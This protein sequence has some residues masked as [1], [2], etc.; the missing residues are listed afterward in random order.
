MQSRMD[1]YKGSNGTV[2]NNNEV[3]GTSR[4]SRNQELYKEVSYAELDNFDLNSNVSILGDNTANIDIGKI[5]DI[6]DEKYNEGTKRKSL[7]DTDEIELPKINLDETREYDIN[8]ILAKAKEEKEFDYEEDRLKK[9]NEDAESILKDIDADE[10]EFDRAESKVINKAKTDEAELLDLINT[11]TAKELIKEEANM[12]TLVGEMDPLDLLTDLRGDDDT[13]VMGAIDAVREIEEMHEE[14]LRMDK[15]D[16]ITIEEAEERE[17]E[18]ERTQGIEEITEEQMIAYD[19]ES[20]DDEDSE[21]DE[22]DD[23][24]EFAELKEDEET[25]EVKVVKG[26]EEFDETFIAGTAEF[27]KQDFDDFD[28]LKESGVTSVMVKILVFLIIIILILGGIVFGD[29]AVSPPQNI[30]QSFVNSGLLHI[31]LIL[32]LLF[33][34]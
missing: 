16:N 11:I 8:S 18:R 6:L 9:L 30:K 13:R 32:L 23:T 25:V 20:E 10:E 14:A 4:V 21:D 3:Q 27:S 2:D 22:E 19:E 26:I 28:D 5:R 24:T 15:E 17:D 7:G 29:D 1:R 33:S 31:F 12:D 34:Y